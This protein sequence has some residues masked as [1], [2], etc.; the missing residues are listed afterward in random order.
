[1]ENNQWEKSVAGQKQS[2]KVINIF[3]GPGLGKSTT[4]LGVTYYL[5]MRGFRAEAPEEYAKSVTWD[6][7][8]A[9]LEDQLYIVANQNRRL[10]RLKEQIDWIVS[11]SPLLLGIHY[12]P[13]DYFPQ[14]Y[15]KFIFEVWNHYENINFLLERTVPYDPVGRNQTEEEAKHIDQGIITMLEE[16]NVEFTKISGPRYK[17]DTISVD[18]IRQALGI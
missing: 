15:K 13:P 10:W 18:L 16:E 12:V 4:A 11:D 2:A 7:N 14:F 1:M 9:K 6:K 5:K 17:G 3:G 8:I